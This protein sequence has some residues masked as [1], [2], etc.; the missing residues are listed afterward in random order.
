MAARAAAIAATD[1]VKALYL[2]DMALAV[3]PR[4]RAALQ[5]RIQALKTLDA[6]SNNSNERGWLAAAIREAEGA[7]RPR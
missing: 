1:P 5:A 7:A 6:S 3:D 4:H 2:T